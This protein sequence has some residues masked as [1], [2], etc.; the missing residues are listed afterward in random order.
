MQQFT[1]DVMIIGGGMVGL[2]L[3]AL[4]LQKTPL[5]VVMLESAEHFPAWQLDHYHHRVSALSLASQRIFKALAVWQDIKALRVSPF[6]KM[7]VWD[8]KSVGRIAFD[9]AEIAEAQLGF[10]VENNAVQQALFKKMMNHPRFTYFAPVTLHTVDVNEARVSVSAS[11]GRLFHA[12]LAVAADGAHS[13]LRTA[14]QIPIVRHPYHQ[15]AIVTTVKTTLPHAKTARQVFHP[16]GPL[17]FLPLAEECTSS[18]VW[19]T[20]TEKADELLQL[21]D[22]E[23]KNKLAKAFFH[24]LGEVI[25]VDQ[26]YAYPLA[27]QEAANYVAARVALVGD[28]AHTVHPLAGQGVNMGLLDAGSLV[29][30]IEDALSLRRDFAS[31]ATLRQYE[32][33]RRADNLSFMFGM[34]AIKKLFASERSSVMHLRALGLNATHYLA[35]A[36]NCFARFAVGDRNHLPRV[37]M[38]TT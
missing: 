29:D 9:S 14:L 6:A 30:V 12:A 2:T 26:R 15:K 13:W 32:R 35:S 19:S 17:A 28:A 4:L 33:W 11:D 23:F 37:A 7:E 22:D 3:A 27:K 36:K 24:R 25:F 20:T 8:A 1:S 31:H 5:S 34:D 38:P 18:I 16:E 10:I 21:S